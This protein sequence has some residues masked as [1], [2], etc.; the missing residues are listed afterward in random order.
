MVES[1]THL[2]NSY[3][4]SPINTDGYTYLEDGVDFGGDEVPACFVRELDSELCQ[5]QA[6]EWEYLARMDSSNRLLFGTGM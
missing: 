2:V 5:A 4:I 3:H 1:I 6:V